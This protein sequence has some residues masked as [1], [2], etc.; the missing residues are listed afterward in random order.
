[1]ASIMLTLPEALKRA[2]A[3][4]NDGKFSEAERLC[5]A[6]IAAKPDFLRS[7]IVASPFIS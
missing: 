6:I 1:M 2:I 3:A 4:Y 7:A 5:R